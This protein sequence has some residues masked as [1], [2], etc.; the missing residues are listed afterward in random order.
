[1]S[2][3]N[4]TSAELAAWLTDHHWVVTAV[5]PAVVTAHRGG[6]KRV[7]ERRDGVW[8]I[9]F[10]RGKVQPGSRADDQGGEPL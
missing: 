1:M 9:A 7:Y 5:K 10:R 3:P 6:S 8:V 4:L 2:P